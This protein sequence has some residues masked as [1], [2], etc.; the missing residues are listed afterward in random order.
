VKGVRCGRCR[1]TFFPAADRCPRCA[2][3]DVA[4]VELADRGAVESRTGGDGWAIG[5][6]RLDDGVLVLAALADDVAVGDRVRHSPAAVVR[7]ERA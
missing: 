5:E 1:A 2:G 7:F 6:V 4:A 3:R